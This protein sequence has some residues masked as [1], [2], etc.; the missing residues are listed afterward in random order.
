MCG[1][2]TC[3]KHRNTAILPVVAR[4]SA[5]GDDISY[6]GRQITIYKYNISPFLTPSDFFRFEGGS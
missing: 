1:K 6:G 5:A 3:L 2:L 4:C